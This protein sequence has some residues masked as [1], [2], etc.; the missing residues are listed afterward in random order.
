M[1]PDRTIDKYKARLVVKGYRQKEGLDYFDTYSP[2]TR[3]TSISMLIVLAA[4]HD[5]KIHQID[6]N[7]IFLNGE[8]EEQNL[9]G[10]T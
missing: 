10:T 6:V 5:L 3:I 9:H 1:K 4:M 7:T 2:V 8:L